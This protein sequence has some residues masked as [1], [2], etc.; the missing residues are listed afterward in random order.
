MLL[1]E[2]SEFVKTMNGYKGELKKNGDQMTY[3]KPLVDFKVPDT[4]DW[5]DKGYVTPIKNQGQCGSCWAFRYLLLFF[6]FRL[7][8]IAIELTV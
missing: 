1:Q 5:R 4:V 7:C 2:H 8:L 3:L 6:S